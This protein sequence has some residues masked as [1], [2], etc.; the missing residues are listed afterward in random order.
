MS[1][2]N[3]SA[4]EYSSSISPD[5]APSAFTGSRGSQQEI[6]FLTAME[7]CT[8]AQVFKHW[9]ERDRSVAMSF[10]EDI[11][12]QIWSGATSGGLDVMLHPRSKEVHPEFASFVA[13]H[14]FDL[15]K[16]VGAEETWLAYLPAWRIRRIS[17]Q[18]AKF[19]GDLGWD[20]LFLSMRYHVTS[21][22]RVE[23]EIN[24]PESINS[25]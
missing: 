22:V 17:K 7:R 3:S 20:V 10:T 15:K 2:S 16:P 18:I 1:Q 9:K 23:W 12:K 8:P 5:G 14:E 6:K 21:S 25:E 13:P 4:T 11:I 24:V 19:L